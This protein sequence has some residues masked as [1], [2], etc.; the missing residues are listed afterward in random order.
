MYMRQQFETKALSSSSKEI[1]VPLFV[2][3]PGRSK[4][5]FECLPPS[6]RPTS[7]FLFCFYLHSKAGHHRPQA[8]WEQ[9]RGG[10][11]NALLQVCG[12]PAP[13]LDVAQGGRHL[14]HGTCGSRAAATVRP[15]V[16]R[17]AAPRRPPLTLLT[18]R[19]G[20]CVAGHRQFHRTLLHLQQ[21]KLHRAQHHQ[22]GHNHRSGEI[23]MQRHQRHRKHCGDHYT[24]SAEPPGTTLAFPGCACRGYNP[25]RYH[26]CVR[27][28]QDA[29]WHYWW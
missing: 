4:T 22:P 11:C 3:P 7:L 16:G 20:R 24:T 23:W 25:S 6:T 9:K 29:G 8:E 15:R 5:I 27:E 14:L 17:A 2:T 1:I 26:R 21:R 13:Y 12:L 28:T 10:K 19:N 18:L